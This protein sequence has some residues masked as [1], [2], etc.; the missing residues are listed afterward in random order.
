MKA[1]TRDRIKQVVATSVLLV[2]LCGVFV[3]SAPIRV[4]AFVTVS[5]WFIF[6]LWTLCS[7]SAVGKRGPTGAL[8]TAYAALWAP[9][10]ALWGFP[11]DDPNLFGRLVDEHGGFW[12]LVAL[13]AT[14]GTL[15]FGWPDRYA[16]GA[17]LAFLLCR[18]ALAERKI[19]DLRAEL[20]NVLAKVGRDS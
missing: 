3:R 7:V 10:L 6:A 11:Q 15:M 12:F 16:E 13:W 17:L 5:L 1:E 18:L 9:G 20:S 19:E 14:A 2:F 4:A 8:S